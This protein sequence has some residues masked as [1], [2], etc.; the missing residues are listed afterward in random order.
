L[1]IGVTGHRP[2]RFAE[3]AQLTVR[4]KL[5]ELF[6]A[7]SEIVGQLQTREAEFF[8]PGPPEVCIVSALAEGADRVVAEAGLGAGFALNAVLP[9]PP[10][11]YE[12]DFETDESKT[13]YRALLAKTSACL[14]LAGTKS[15]AA[16]I[17]RAYEAVGLLTL[18]Q[19]DILV[20]VWDGNVSSG[21]GGTEDIVQHAVATGRP[22]LRFDEKGNGPFLLLAQGAEPV[23]ARDLAA[24]ATAASTMDAQALSH[25]VKHLC[26][27]PE[28]GGSGYQGKAEKKARTFLQRFLH[29]RERRLLPFAFAYPLLLAL[30]GGNGRGFWKSFRLK[31]YLDGAAAEW[32]SYWTALGEAGPSVCDP[33][34]DIVMQRFAWADR[35]ANY[36]GQLHRSGYVGNFFLAALAVLFAAFGQWWSQCLE[37]ATIFVIMGSTYWGLSAQWHERWV[38]YRQLSAHL[39]Y[40]RILALTA[41]STWETGT[42]RASDDLEAGPVWVNWYYKMTV[43]EMGVVNARIDGRYLAIVRRAI[44]EGEIEGQIDYHRRN[45]ERMEST[46][47]WLEWLS[48][49]AFAVTFVICAYEVTAGMRAG[50]APSETLHE[51]L[52]ALS[53]SLPAF[54]AALFGIRVHGDFEGSAK[55]SVEMERRLAAVAARLGDGAPASFAEL[56]ALTEHAAIIMAGEVGDWGF[57]YRARPLALPT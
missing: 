32:R 4:R 34:R 55:R 17:E 6:A 46:Y 56:S 35:L 9:F 44:R 26:A 1:R 52:R 30:F 24:R 45:A 57:V 27:P 28:T 15:D 22:V 38:D 7:L 41:S 54:G 8:A 10:D 3:A 36:Y 12:G 42:P 53:V 43:R 39:R 16:E 11:V 37:L 25:I 19:C 2:N 31:P 18:R 20:A 50:L 21:R 40:L 33:I 23:D 47:W 51:T 14:T 48:R 5:D 29:E 13:R 49:I